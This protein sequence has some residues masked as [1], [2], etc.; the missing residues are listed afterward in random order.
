[1]IEAAPWPRADRL[2]RSDPLWLGGD[3]AFSVD[4]SGGRVLWMFGDSFIATRP[5]ETR[6]QAT[7]VRNSVAIETGYDPARATIRF[8]SGHRKGKP[9]SLVPSEGATWFWPIHGIRIGNR[10]LLFYMRETADPDKQSMGFQSVGWNAFMVDN[11]DAEPSQWRLRKLAGPEMQGKMFIGMAVLHEG[12]FL[13]AFALD[14]V[15]HNAYLLRWRL[16]EAA[17]GRLSSPQWWCGAADGWRGDPAHRQIVIRNAGS[18]FS[19]QRDPRGGF[20]EVNSAGFG[21]S[22]IVFRGAAHLEGPWSQPE[23]LYDPPES[24]APHAF[25]YGAKAHP[26]LHGAGL[27]ITYTANGSNE[28]LATDMSIYFPRFVRVTFGN[29]L[30]S[31]VARAHR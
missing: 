11:P 5:G 29:E 21:A 4:L 24:N 3:G 31:S 1:K 6:R 23:M 16:N 17:A 18:E 19:V 7:F 12:G 30:K 8:Y 25:V 9:A 22:T 20:L 27:V 28:R 14:D 10:L 13:Y 2:F 15:T 26:E